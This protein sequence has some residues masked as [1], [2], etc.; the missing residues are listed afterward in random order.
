MRYRFIDELK[1]FHENPRHVLPDDINETVK[2]EY[3]K[4]GCDLAPEIIKEFQEHMRY[5]KVDFINSDTP[6]IKYS[7]QIDCGMA[8]GHKKIEIREKGKWTAVIS[9]TIKNKKLDKSKRKG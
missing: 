7:T 4:L 3:T 1:K 6:H 8:D 2:A 5:G 9:Y